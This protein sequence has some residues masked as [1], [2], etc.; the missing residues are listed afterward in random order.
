MSVRY[1]LPKARAIKMCNK[2]GSFK[3]YLHGAL[4]SFNHDHPEWAIPKE[5]H[6]SLVKR[7]EGQL[8]EEFAQLVSDRL[9][10]NWLEIHRPEWSELCKI[11]GGL[12]IVIAEEMEKR[13]R[14]GRD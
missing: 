11:R 2:D 1:K 6:T 5:A 9:I 13:E 10:L 12:R 3:T 14:E 7:L 4:K 8:K